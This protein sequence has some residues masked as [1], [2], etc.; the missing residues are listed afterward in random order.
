MI[1]CAVFV[2]AV[3]GLVAAWPGNALAHKVNIFAYAEG[4][5]VFAESYFPDG[6]PVENG[7]VE[8]LDSQ[9]KKLLEVTTDKA[10]KVSFPIPAKDDLT[11]VINA[12]M[13][14]KNSFTLKKNEL[15]DAP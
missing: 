9:G 3:A 15:G 11:I 12:S 14:H 2:L 7:K 10:G 13:G 1:A 4:G 8:V 6:S 5:K